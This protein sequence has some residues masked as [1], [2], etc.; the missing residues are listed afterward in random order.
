MLN[1]SCVQEARTS[2]VFEHECGSRLSFLRPKNWSRNQVLE[3]VRWQYQAAKSTTRDLP[4][5]SVSSSTSTRT[6]DSQC[7][8]HSAR[9]CSSKHWNPFDLVSISRPASLL[10][11]TEA[12]CKRR[13]NNNNQEQGTDVEHNATERRSKKATKPLEGGKKG[14]ATVTRKHA[15]GQF[16]IEMLDSVPRTPARRKRS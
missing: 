11:W 2:T 14:H 5:T 7:S 1:V 13:H 10:P 15:P 6:M 9:K 8:F 12:P 16:I 3:P 4:S